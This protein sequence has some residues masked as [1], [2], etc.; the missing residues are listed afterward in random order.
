MQSTTIE[1]NAQQNEQ[2]ADCAENPIAKLDAAVE[3]LLR[4]TEDFIVRTSYKTDRQTSKDICA[5][6]NRRQDLLGY[7]QAHRQ[8]CIEL[9][10]G[11]AFLM[12]QLDDMIKNLDA[13]I[14]EESASG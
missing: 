1:R 13:A 11:Y 9:K 10:R 7:L 8:K 3:S 12:A 2:T 6:K 5:L 14:A 4:V